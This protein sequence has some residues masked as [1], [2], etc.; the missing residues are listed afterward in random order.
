[1]S[2]NTS[3]KVTLTKQQQPL[4]EK[5]THIPLSKTR[6]EYARLEIEHEGRPEDIDRENFVM[7]TKGVYSRKIPQIQRIRLADGTEWLNW[8]EIRTGKSAGGRKLEKIFDN[9][10]TY[11]T[12]VPYEELEFDQESEEY[13]LVKKGEKE[14]VPCYQIPFSEKALNELFEDIIPYKTQYSILQEYGSHVTVSKK[15]IGY[16]DFE[17]LYNIKTKTIDTSELI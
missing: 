15:D 12:P 14:Q 3:T 8:S 1:M 16:K 10:G 13:K 9:I 11:F 17:K 6:S 2:N 5:E 7:L 4:V